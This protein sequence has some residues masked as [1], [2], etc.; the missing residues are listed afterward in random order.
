MLRDWSGPA[1]RLVLKNV[2]D[3]TDLD[4]GR[5]LVRLEA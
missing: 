4:G 5:I 3:A 2:A 1:G